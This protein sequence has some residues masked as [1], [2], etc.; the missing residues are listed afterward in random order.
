MLAGP[1]TTKAGTGSGPGQFEAEPPA[2]PLPGAEADRGGASG[3][4][5]PGTCRLQVF[6]GD[7]LL[8]RMQLWHD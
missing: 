3:R 6:E 7:P 5:P 2:H 1:L 8:Q 4:G